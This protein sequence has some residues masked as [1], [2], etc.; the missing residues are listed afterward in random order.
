MAE[1]IFSART[2]ISRSPAEV[3]EWVADYRN[4]RRALEGVTRWQPT[5]R[6]SRGRGAR[7]DVAVSELGLT[8]E[9]MLV[10]DTWDE[11]NTISWRSE[12]GPIAQRGGWRLLALEAGT[13]VELTIAYWPPGGAIG[14]L[15][16]ARV[17]GLLRRRLQ[18][19]VARMKAIIEEE[20]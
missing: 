6:R 1:R 19:A 4:A 9:T 12:S 18:R 17:E 2:L 20:A 3:F 13:E 8:L 11:P 14:A 16:A 15:L 5:G 10:L 7:F